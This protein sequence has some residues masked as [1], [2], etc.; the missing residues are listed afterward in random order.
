MKEGKKR[1]FRGV[2]TA[3]VT[4]MRE[5]GEIDEEALGRLIE[6]QIEGGVS[7]LVIAGTTG[8]AATLEEREHKELLRQ[9][10]MLVGGRV[11][12]IAGVGG[13]STRHCERLAA[14]AAQAGADGILAVTPYYNKGNAQGLIRHFTALE[15]AGGIPLLLYNV[16]ARTGVDIP[17]AV[18]RELAAHP[19]VV[20]IKEA[21]GHPLKTA[22]IIAETGG[23]LPVYSG[24]DEVILP[25]LAVGG[26]GVVS[27]VSNVLPR[28]TAT[29]TER[30]FK[31]DVSGAAERQ[32]ELLPLIDALFGEVNPIPVKTALGMLELC[33][34]TM[35]LPLCEARTETRERLR[36][37]LCSWGLLREA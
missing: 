32:L 10:V 6:R 11:P 33:G 21:S 14:G 17:L 16:P 37:E 5:N 23:T 30:F 28:E 18:C 1:L 9:S 29:L 13:T 8:E 4:P 27:V 24:N 3:L 36:R 34:E 19:G 25:V 31:G 22:R 35:R 26:E 15:E 2:A 20:G 7:A 12:V